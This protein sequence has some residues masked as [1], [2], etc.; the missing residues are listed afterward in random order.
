MKKK[1]LF[2]VITAVV[3]TIAAGAGFLFFKS[4]PPKAP[5]G[6]G[7]FLAKQYYI[8]NGKKILVSV[9]RVYFD[10]RGNMIYANDRIPGGENLV[11]RFEYDDLNRI[12][13]QK[14]MKK[15]LFGEV[16]V[17]AVYKKYDGD[18]ERVSESKTVTRDRSTVWTY[19]Y[20]EEGRCVNSKCGTDY[21]EESE[22]N[23]KGVEISKVIH[24]K[25]LVLTEKEYNEETRE[26]S[27]YESYSHDR[28]DYS[29]GKTGNLCGII[30]L[31]EDGRIAD[32]TEYWIA[33]DSDGIPAPY[34]KIVYN[35]L[36][37]GEL[38]HEEN[39]YDTEGVLI[40]QRVVDKNGREVIC[41]EYENGAEV[42]CVVTEY[43]AERPEY[44][45]QKVEITKVYRCDENGEEVLFSE[46]H[47]WRSGTNYPVQTVISAEKNRLVV[48]WDKAES[49]TS[50]D[51]VFSDDGT[52]KEWRT[53]DT[54]GNKKVNNYYDR[55][56]N[57]IKGEEYDSDGKITCEYE[58]EYKYY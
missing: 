53:Y 11:Y 51:S 52:L 18:S 10:E 28:K 34:K 48:R 5:K 35:Y 32:T 50:V 29:N 47:L 58:V 31:R 9:T 42:K 17:E 14:E 33:W 55:N 54:D 56:G 22:Y 57:W 7:S 49:G 15:T 30:R 44:P 46:S 39:S 25:D 6:T 21:S 23:E 24:D 1:T 43:D 38:D 36:D 37:D 8:E 26:I 13:V 40:Q 4:R 12:T 3:L 19:Q 16:L 45:K 2:M 27:C 41:R 20:D